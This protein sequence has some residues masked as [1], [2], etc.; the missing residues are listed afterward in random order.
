VAVE[1]REESTQATML[2]AVPGRFL[3]PL[4]NE[5]T[6]GDSYVLNANRGNIVCRRR[7]GPEDG[8]GSAVWVS[9]K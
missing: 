7:C 5:S 8:E 4:A 3:L 2:S 6:T 1:E 9:H